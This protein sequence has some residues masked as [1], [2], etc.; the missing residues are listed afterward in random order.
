VATL[1]YKGS[2]TTEQWDL[3]RVQTH[4]EKPQMAVT[5]NGADYTVS[6]TTTSNATSGTQTVTFSTKTARVNVN[7]TAEQ[8]HALVPLSKATIHSMLPRT[9]FVLE[10]VMVFGG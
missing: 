4:D 1:K 6:F 9:S 5:L 10:G 8:R 7:R 3:W 2:V